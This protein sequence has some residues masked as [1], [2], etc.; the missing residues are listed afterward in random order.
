[1]P[2]KE[3]WGSR[4]GVILAVMGGA[5][6]LG[7]FLRFPGL[8]ATCGGGAFMIP[9]LVAVLVLAVPISWAEW[10][11]GR[12]GGSKGFNSVPGIF[13]TLTKRPYGAWLGLLHTII[14][15]IIFIYYTLI[16]AFCLVYACSYLMDSMHLGTP[17]AY[18]DS[19]N[20]FV[21]MDENGAVF[22]E[23]LFSPL[24]AA[25][26][27]CYAVNF[28]LIYRGISRGIE[29]F[30]LFAMPLLIVCGLV[31][32][33]RVITLG[34]PMGIE[35]QSYRDSLNFMWNPTH[36]GQTFLESLS[37][38]ETW[39]LAAG[40]VF[41]S[42]SIGFGLIITYASYM[43]KDTDVASSS[44]TAIAGNGF[45]EI[46]IGGM[47]VVPVAVMF[48]GHDALNKETLGSTFALG[49][50]ALPSVFDKM[51]FG[52][53]IGFLFF[54]LLFL[55]AVTSSISEL[56]PPIAFIQEGLGVGRNRSC[57][58]LFLI[59]FTGTCLVM[60][61]SKNLQ[62][63]D[64]FDFWAG[65]FFIFIMATVQILIFGWVFGIER[66]MAEI[67]RGAKM[68]VPNFIAFVIKYVSPLYLI[69]IFGAWLSINLPKRIAMIRSESVV[70]L[71]CYFM[72][73][74]AVFFS[75]IL[76]YALKRWR[77]TRRLVHLDDVE[78]VA[79]K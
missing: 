28:F 69:V 77:K 61:Y 13:Y 32:M 79:G 19:F 7:N 25:L 66:G 64:T 36:S 24:F 67:R 31:L 29:R 26:L 57:L 72:F 62:A 50:Q 65:N 41:F 46:I 73:G 43:K 17:Q 30:C 51:W 70:Q 53:G 44:L 2:K 16:E 45:C 78:D 48:L 58:F 55:A 20:R 35:G 40:Q 27:V 8:V 75:L 74:L 33:V 22:A 6:G 38:P 39:L 56:Q 9:Y 4:L 18:L 71:S 14:P 52:Q 63:L 11:A 23:G 1:M 76:V 10:A 37:N 59:T 49:F 3:N 15:I 12:Y 47:M 60:Y 42:Y 5:V 34:N 21:G 68:Q 54:F